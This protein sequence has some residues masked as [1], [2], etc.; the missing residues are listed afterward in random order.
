[1]GNA[2]YRSAQRNARIEVNAVQ[3]M[4]TVSVDNVMIWRFVL[5]FSLFNQWFTTISAI[6]VRLFRYN[7]TPHLSHSSIEHR[8][9]CR[10]SA[11]LDM[12]IQFP[13]SGA[14]ETRRATQKT[15]RR[16]T[17]KRKCIFC[18]HRIW[19]NN[20]ELVNVIAMLSRHNNNSKQ[21]AI[22]CDVVRW[23]TT[24]RIWAR[25][26]SY[27]APHLWRLAIVWQFSVIVLAVVVETRPGNTNSVKEQSNGLYAFYFG[28]AV[29]EEIVCRRTVI[30]Q[31][32]HNI[33][34]PPCISICLLYFVQGVKGGGRN[35]ELNKYSKRKAA[36]FSIK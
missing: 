9:R 17:L 16:K 3:T 6:C 31:T 1:M 24:I 18:N 4:A 29:F 13:K 15:E 30:K 26:I 21:T 23:A 5:G 35:N 20:P 12:K 27:C 25:C 10:R 14:H 28:S 8:N 32:S 22:V 7:R 33:Q 11:A 36:I 19:Y 2:W 34:S